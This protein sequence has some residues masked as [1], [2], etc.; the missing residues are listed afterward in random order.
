MLIRSCCVSEKTQ[1]CSSSRTEQWS[2]LFLFL[3]LSNVPATKVAARSG[4]VE[5]WSSPLSG[6]K[7]SS[8]ECSQQGE[9]MLRQ[10]SYT[11]EETCAKQWQGYWG[12]TVKILSRMNALNALWILT[13]RRKRG[14]EQKVSFFLLSFFCKTTKSFFS[15]FTSH[16][17]L[18]CFICSATSSETIKSILGG[19]CGPFYHLFVNALPAHCYAL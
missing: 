16:F 1:R 6:L 14:C 19:T 9:Y 8:T 12:K 18:M 5:Y 7:H 11:S 2:I 4:I 13:F 3:S 15:L 17:Y 10:E